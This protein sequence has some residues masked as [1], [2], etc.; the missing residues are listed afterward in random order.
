MAEE[1]KPATPQSPAPDPATPAG[2][3]PTST[4]PAISDV[5]DSKPETANPA[6]GEDQPKPMTG[7]V[8]DPLSDGTV[9]TI[10][11]PGNS[12]RKV[13]KGKAS[14]SNVYRRADVMTT[15]LTFVGAIV[16][17]G[18]MLGGYYYFAQKDT[19]K[20]VPTPKV[21]NLDKSELEK[22]GAFFSGN[23]AGKSAEVLTVSSSSLFNNRVAINSDLKV[24]G[25]IQISGTSALTDLTVER[26]ATLAAT[27]IRGALNVS[28]PTTLQ[29]PATL[30]GGATINGSLN[31]TGNASFGGS[32]AAGTINTRDLS[33]SGN[34]SLNG[35]VSV[36]GGAAS[37]TA[38]SGLVTSP[39]VDGTDSSGTVSFTVNASAGNPLGASLVTINFRAP[40]ARAPT[41]VITPNS[42]PGAAIQ[43]YVLKTA[44]GF[45]IAA[46]SLPAN[47]NAT[48][49]SFD[50][51]V[52][53]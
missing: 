21:T 34:F 24:V 4:S 15:L 44:T 45:T 14:I 35:H 17:G 39:G 3:K 19:T 49:Y 23:S 13:T 18:V 40:Y 47:S 1:P 22:L 7:M 20:P 41:V 38:A 28:G 46:Y 5:V 53:Q 16:A 6:A 37:A 31:A 50:Y 30:A 36:G 12:H 42:R 43:A 9:P 48:S 26:T 29:S 11:A 10:L 25:G 52:V 32:I 51:W 8:A 27:S 33:V 2:D